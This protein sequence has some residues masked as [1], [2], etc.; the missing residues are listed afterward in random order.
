MLELRFGHSSSNKCVDRGVYQVLFV[1]VQV[2]MEML[3][4]LW[5]S[6]LILPSA[7]AVPQN[8][9]VLHTND[10]HSRL[11]QFN[12]YGAPC[13]DVEAREGKCYGGVARRYTKVQELLDSYGRENV[14]FLD[15]GDRFT[16]T[17]WHNVY[18]GMATAHF[19]NRLG[20]DAMVSM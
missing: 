11:M 4:I 15:A 18:R 1:C 6:V 10:V 16:G 8:I 5:L 13:E 19:M 9:T 3:T 7:S 2:K 12:Y 17:L 14:I 20:Y